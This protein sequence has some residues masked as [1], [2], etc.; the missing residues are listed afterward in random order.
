MALLRDIPLESV[1]EF[2]TALVRVDGRPEPGSAAQFW[3]SLL[4]E[5]A[6]AIPGRGACILLSDSPG[7]PCRARLFPRRQLQEALDRP[8]SGSYEEAMREVLDELALCGPPDSV[9]LKVEAGGEEALWCSLPLDAVDAEVFLYLLS[10]LLR[11]GGVPDDAWGAER[12]GG[13]ATFESRGRPH[14]VRFAVVS[15]HVAEGLY[16][17][18]VRLEPA[19]P[20]TPS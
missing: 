16:R 5:V 12:C 17:H 14:P 2:G 15:R 20:A 8:S 10:W 13:G 3:W 9:Q 7:R 1:T 18:E 19:P 4:D 11:W 6:A